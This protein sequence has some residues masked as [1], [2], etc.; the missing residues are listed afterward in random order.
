[1]PKQ[2]I[3]IC[4][5]NCW[6]KLLTLTSIGLILMGALLPPIGIIDN[7]ILVGVGELEAFA[8][9][10]ESVVAFQSG[11]DAKVKIKEIEFEIKKNG[12][13]GKENI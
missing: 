11:L 2:L 6:L 3:N 9:I 7:S 12:N 1:M 4:T 13:K 5:S 8:V 10:G